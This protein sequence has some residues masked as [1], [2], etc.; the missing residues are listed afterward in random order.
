MFPVALSSLL[1]YPEEHFHMQKLHLHNYL[2]S[3][4]AHNS[5]NIAIAIIV[6]FPIVPR[7]KFKP[8]FELMEFLRVAWEPEQNVFKFKTGYK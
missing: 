6:F 3:R 7:I 5:N 1:L 4:P 8:C 2:V